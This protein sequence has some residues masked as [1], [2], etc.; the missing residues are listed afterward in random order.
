M[1]NFLRMICICAL[2]FLWA[3]SPSHKKVGTSVVIKNV[4]AIDA[5]NGRRENVDIIIVDDKISRIGQDI[6]AD[7]ISTH[8]AETTAI[9]EGEGRY[10]IP[11]LW[12]SHVHLTYYPDVGYEI[13]FPL[14]IAHG[15][16]SLRDTGGHLEKI[17]PAIEVAKIDPAA[18]DL[19]YAGPLLDGENPV[20][21]GSEPAF[22]DLSV[23]LETAQAARNYV[24]DLAVQGVSF[25]KAYEMLPPGIFAAV[26]TQADK[27]N[28]P[29]SSH[30]P[31]T[32]TAEEAVRAGA[33]EMQHLRNLDLS[34]ARNADELL[35][36]RQAD[37]AEQGGTSSGQLRK[38]M[39]ADQRSLALSN[40]DNK[41]CSELI[42]F[43]ADNTV[44]QTPTLTVTRFF[45]HRLWEQ[46]DYKPALDLMPEAIAQRWKESSSRFITYDVPTEAQSYDDWVVGM[47]PKMEKAGVPM[48]AGTDAPIGYLVP[49]A[50]LHEEMVLLS[51]AGVSNKA[52]LRAATYAPARFLGVESQTGL[53]QEGMTADLVILASDPLADM[54]NIRSVEAVIK[55]GRVFDKAAIE[56]LKRQ[57]QQP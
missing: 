33:D 16:T 37:I 43:L 11:G 14:S 6:A 49:G 52:I 15:V 22:P 26:I 53:I 4:M 32:M 36:I 34:C 39:H 19:Y 42:A 35:K 3:C 44:Y 40:Q 7:F 47:L 48:L 17:R 23:G 27:H 5:E 24:D 2:I 20:Y 13:F 10:V 8:R 9:I 54:N 29:V 30:I 25:V 57:A 50:S 51:Q 12:D 45:T 55:K 56:K 28:L 18:P 31:L 46:P 41:K 21:D 1:V 38:K